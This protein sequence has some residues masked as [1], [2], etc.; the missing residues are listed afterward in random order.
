MGLVLFQIHEYFYESTSRYMGNFIGFS[1]E[2]QES[3]VGLGEGEQR[4]RIA[5]E[6]GVVKRGAASTNVY[7]LTIFR[8]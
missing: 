5:R 1:G 7:G 6:N 2:T 8:K 4:G 3:L